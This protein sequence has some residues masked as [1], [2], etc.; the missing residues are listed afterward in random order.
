MI[1][2]VALMVVSGV[3]IV[4]YVD[5]TMTSLRVDRTIRWIGKQILRAADAHEHAQRH[6]VIVDR[7]DIERPPAAADLVA[8]SDGYVVA[9]DTGRLSELA[10]AHGTCV[11]IAGRDRVSSRPRGAR[12]MGG[13][14]HVA[15]RCGRSR[16]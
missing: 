1:G 7:T 5:S 15:G 12:R 9:V 11:V 14:R 4:A 10:T 8:A 16:R 2:G 6:D 13:A 3:A